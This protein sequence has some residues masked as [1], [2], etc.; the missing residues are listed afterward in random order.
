[1]IKLMVGTILVLLFL[2]MLKI[3]FQMSKIAR[4]EKELLSV[5]IDEEVATL[6][7][8]IDTRRTR[9]EDSTHNPINQDPEKYST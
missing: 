1:M 5:K 8:E 7:K 4:K 3:L 6:D 2:Y 9:L